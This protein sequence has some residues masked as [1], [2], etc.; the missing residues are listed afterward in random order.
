MR[1]PAE[2]PRAP[3]KSSDDSTAMPL[4]TIA[5]RNAA[6]LLPGSPEASATSGSGSPSVCATSK[7][8]AARKPRTALR[9]VVGGV[10]I[11][12]TDDRRQN[13]DALL[14]LADEAAHRAPG[15]EASDARRGRT[16]RRDERDVVPAER[17]PLDY[18]DWTER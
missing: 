15:L 6:V 17:S 5:A 13:R 10:R 18:V 2:V 7:T 4:A 3:S 12:T 11:A 16:L 9:V 8:Y 14:A 1:P